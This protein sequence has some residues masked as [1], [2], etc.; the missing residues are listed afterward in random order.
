M[1]ESADAK[2]MDTEGHCILSLC[3]L[4]QIMAS[5]TMNMLITL[6][7]I[8]RLYSE[9]IT[10]IFDYLLDIFIWISGTYLKLIM[11][12][13]FAIFPKQLLFLSSPSQSLNPSNSN[14]VT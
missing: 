1:V 4:I 11:S 8:S 3:Y 10:C 2:A 13:T 6:K 9:Y 7:F 5:N 14:P 12:R